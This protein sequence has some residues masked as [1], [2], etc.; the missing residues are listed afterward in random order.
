M[1]VL[2]KCKLTRWF[3]QNRANK[4]VCYLLGAPLN[5]AVLAGHV[6]AIPVVC[7]AAGQ[8]EVGVT[9]PHRQ[10]AGTLLGVTLSFAPTTWEA[11][12]TCVHTAAHKSGNIEEQKLISLRRH[13]CKN[14]AAL[15]RN[16]C[17]LTLR[18]ALAKLLTEVLRGDAGTRGVTGLPRVVTWLVIIHVIGRAICKGSE[19]KLSVIFCILPGRHQSLL[20]L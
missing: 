18:A 2:R 15:V 17:V 20:Q 13:F 9:L 19:V 7:S 8:A 4:T 12:L 6:L 1:V 11:V 3:W 5:G 14:L 10:V 16:V